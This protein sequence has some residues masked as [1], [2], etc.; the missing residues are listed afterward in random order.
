MS[1]YKYTIEEIKEK[2]KIINPNIEI[3]STEYV[4]AKTHLDCRCLVD[5][6]EWKSSWSNLSQKKGCPKCSSRR[7]GKSK[8]L[9]MEIVK[10]KL[11]A[12]NP[13]V[14]ILS[15]MYITS[16]EKLKC[17]CL[18]DGHEWEAK[19]ESLLQ[20][21]GCP[22]CAIRQKTLTLS[23]VK[24]R[25]AKINPN[26]EILSTEYKHSQEK[27]KCRCLI[28][29][30]EWSV[31]WSHLNRGVGCPKCSKRISPT[32]QEVKKILKEISPNIKVLSEKHINST[33]KLK[34]KCLI[35][36]HEWSALWCHLQKGSGCPEC[37][38][39]LSKAEVLIR[40]ELNDLKLKHIREYIFED[41]LGDFNHPLRFDF[42]IFYSG[43]LHCLIE[44]DGEFHYKKFYEE[45]NLER[46]QKYD[47]IKNEYCIKNNI[48]LIRI[49]YWEKE[50]ISEILTDIFICK[51]LNNKFIINNQITGQV[52]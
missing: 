13:N 20:G 30:Y 42:A 22:K 49:P 52:L 2:L 16:S 18:I 1:G 36:G 33:T 47:K 48:P 45:Q 4:N 50:N 25:L 38:R 7:N 35:D 5:G 9:T 32:I 29:D 3:L 10:N 23:S 44:Y 37:G 24:N 11:N 26:I 12:V 41:L 6:C 27:L 34:C 21:S 15:E 17:K 31:T 19:W 14:E 46:R 39:K 51:N 8:R 40:N 43:K 28:D